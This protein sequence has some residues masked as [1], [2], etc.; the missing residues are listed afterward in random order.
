[1]LG[2]FVSKSGST[3][4]WLIY[5]SVPGKFNRIA[6]NAAWKKRGAEMAETVV[7]AKEKTNAAHLRCVERRL[8]LG[9]VRPRPVRVR[10]GP[11][12]VRLDARTFS[13]YPHPPHICHSRILYTAQAFNAIH[14]SRPVVT[15]LDSPYKVRCGWSCL[16]LTA[17]YHP[18]ILNKTY[19]CSGAR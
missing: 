14:F 8:D 10:L 6:G 2:S 4:E 3:R 7:A 11:V 19:I 9:E 13:S 17:F 16:A 12:S 18:G 15:V 5:V 1:M